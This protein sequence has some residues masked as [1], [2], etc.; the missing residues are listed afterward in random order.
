MFLIL[1]TVQ[2]FSTLAVDW[3]EDAHGQGCGTTLSSPLPPVW[4]GLV[5]GPDPVCGASL[6][7]LN[8]APRG[9]S[10]GT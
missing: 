10:L 4:P 6:L 7:V 3:L 8:S 9:Y 5:S 1:H 2:K